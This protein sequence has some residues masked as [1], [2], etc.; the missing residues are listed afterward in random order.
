LHHINL[1]TV[2]LQPA[3]E[4][5]AVASGLVGDN[6]TIHRHAVHVCAS[7]IALDRRHECTGLRRDLLLGGLLRPTWY[8][9]SDDPAAAAEFDGEDQSVVVVDSVDAGGLS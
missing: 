3:C 7:L 8:L 4:P 9:D 1:N 5:E 6:H 2:L